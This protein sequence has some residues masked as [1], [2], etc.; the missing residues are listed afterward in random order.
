MWSRLKETFPCRY[1]TE[2]KSEK[3]QDFLARLF[4]PP[5]EIKSICSPSILR[6]D[7]DNSN[8]QKRYEA[9]IEYSRS[10]NYLEVYEESTSPSYWLAGPVPILEWEKTALDVCERESMQCVCSDRVWCCQWTV[11][12]WD[13]VISLTQGNRIASY[14]GYIVKRIVLWTCGF[15]GRKTLDVTNFFASYTLGEGTFCSRIAVPAPSCFT[16]HVTL[17]W[18]RAYVLTDMCQC[19][20]KAQMLCSLALLCGFPLLYR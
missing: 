14:C 9:V 8:L 1:L 7:E 10:E 12:D 3:L 2:S 13:P 19:K 4:D 11:L 6:D 16:L 5:T 18:T 17:G 15:R 20:G